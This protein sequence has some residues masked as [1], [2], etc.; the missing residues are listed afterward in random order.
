MSTP[1]LI[2]ARAVDCVRE[3]AGEVNTRDGLEALLLVLEKMQG[4][5]GFI[6]GDTPIALLYVHIQRKIAGLAPTMPSTPPA[7]T[8]P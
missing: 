1:I 6:T 2:N 8:S 4:N 5:T 3:V 7:D